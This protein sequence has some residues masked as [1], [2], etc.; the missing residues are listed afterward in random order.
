MN[1]VKSI[2]VDTNLLLYILLGNK[3]IATHLNQFDVGISFISEI[4]L[5]GKK[6]I[7]LTD[8]KTI[9]NFLSN[10]KLFDYTTSIKNIAIE[11][12]QQH[13]LKTPD[14]LILATAKYYNVPLFTADKDFKKI[15]IHSIVI[16]EP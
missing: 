16:L 8:I 12:K 7:S 4:E 9:N 1:G 13:K 5:L 14:A 6:D 2:L 10:L 11:I 15:D 3:Q